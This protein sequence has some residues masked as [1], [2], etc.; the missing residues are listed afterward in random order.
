MNDVFLVTSV[1][2]PKEVES[3]YNCEERFEKTAYTIQ[4]IKKKYPCAQ[5][6]VLEASFGEKT[7]VM[8]NDVYMFYIDHTGEDDDS[9]EA[10]ILPTFLA[11]SCYKNLI[12]TADFKVYIISGRHGDDDVVD[13]SKI[14]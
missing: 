11:S 12:R 4:T 14:L 7:L 3:S 8:F 6:I 9:N 1:V 13:L 10:N 5:I 2:R